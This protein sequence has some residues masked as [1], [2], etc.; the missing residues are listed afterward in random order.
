MSGKLDWRKPV[1]AKV[2]AK[3]IQ[4]GS[5]SCSSEIGGK[6]E[7]ILQ[8]WWDSKLPKP[9]SAPPKSPVKKKKK[10]ASILKSKKSRATHEE[11]LAKWK[12]RQK[13]QRVAK[14]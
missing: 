9:V 5:A 6:E 10:Q 1:Q 2:A 7:A 3:Q 13:L 14:S 11:R 4:V 12:A 8:A